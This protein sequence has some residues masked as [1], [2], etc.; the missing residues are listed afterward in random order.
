MEALVRSGIGALTLIDADDIC[1]GNANRQSHAMDGN[2]GRA[3]VAVLAE[4]A[5]LINPECAVNSLECFV[6]PANL[7]ETIAREFDLV[8]DCCDA[9]RTKVEMI[10]LCRRRKQPLVVC[11]SAG[12]R[13]DPTR[14]V[15]RDL[16]RTEHDALLA[17]IRRKL[18]AEFNFPRGP[19]RYFSVP[20]VY[21]LENV[22][23]PQADGSVRG[24]RPVG[25]D[26]GRLDCGEGLG[27]VMHVTAAFA[28]AAV[29]TALERLLRAPGPTTRSDDAGS[30][31]D[32][33]Q[34]AC[35]EGG[36]A[37]DLGG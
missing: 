20:A 13:V 22:R 15:V 1:I 11:G 21:S 27:A 36:G 37:R 18:R 9:F 8:L 30:G 16:S 23:Y 6:T 26:A 31:A 19:E 17:M 3:K 5:R 33:Q 7:R 12:G 4:R 14:I 25:V 2:Y 28:M 10:A 34:A 35:I 24:L 32:T 29:A